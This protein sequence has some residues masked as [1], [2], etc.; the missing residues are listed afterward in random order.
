MRLPTTLTL[1]VENRALRRAVGGVRLGGRAFDLLVTLAGSTERVYSTRELMAA[2]WPNRAV[3]DNNLRVQIAA[4]RRQ[5]GRDAIINVPGRGYRLSPQMLQRLRPSESAAAPAAAHATPAL[6]LERRS[7]ALRERD[8]RAVWQLLGECAETWVDPAGWH[9]HLLGGLS[10]LI[11][12]Q[13]GMHAEATR[14]QPGETPQVLS[15]YEHGWPTPEQREHFERGHRDAAGPFGGSPL[16]LRFREALPRQAD[17]ACRRADLIDDRAWLGNEFHQRY[18]RPNAMHDFLLSAIRTGRGNRFDLLVF[19]GAGHRP[20]ARDARLL[21]H[22]HRQL[23][24][25]IG[26]RLA[27]ATDASMHGLDAAQRGLLRHVAAGAS[28]R[29][30][31][32]RLALPTSTVERRIDA[33]CAH[34]G[35]GDRLALM[36]YLIARRPAPLRIDNV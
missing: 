34:F 18:L 13:V 29:A 9:D 23:L 32:E 15:A 10:A 11:G 21:R 5:L 22:A 19:G 30:I 12:L 28:S 17:L 27:R 14:L 31:A 20:T 25:M 26:T 35:L 6:Q 8:L 7:D 3:E 4:L 2:V 16:D 1:D 24:P 33:L 36:A